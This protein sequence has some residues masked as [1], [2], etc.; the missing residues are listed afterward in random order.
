[1]TKLGASIL[2]NV[3]HLRHHTFLYYEVANYLTFSW[4]DF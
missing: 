3:E 1:M 2:K 4:L